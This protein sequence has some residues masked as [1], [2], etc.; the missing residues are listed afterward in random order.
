[1][2]D[3]FERYKDILTTMNEFFLRFDI[4][5]DSAAMEI[6]W[7][8]K[9]PPKYVSDTNTEVDFLFNSYYQ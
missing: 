3:I 1:M 9:L 5:L 8:I 6:M 4:S 7:S 2:V